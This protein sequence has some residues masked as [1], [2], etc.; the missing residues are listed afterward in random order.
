MEETSAD[1]A[2]SITQI[3]GTPSPL[4]GDFLKLRRFPESQ[5]KPGPLVSVLGGPGIPGGFVVM[6]ADGAAVA[7]GLGLSLAVQAARKAAMQR[8]RRMIKEA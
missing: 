1:A 6:G 5:V 3:E 8:Y 4:P 7:E 2:G